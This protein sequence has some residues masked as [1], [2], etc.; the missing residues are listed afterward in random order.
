MTLIFDRRAELDGKAAGHAFLVGVSEYIYLPG[1]N[2]PKR[3]ELYNL[4]RLASPALSAWELCRWLIEHC[5]DLA[6][7]L[8]TI[9]LLASPSARELPKMTPLPAHPALVAPPVP[10]RASWDN[11]LSEALAWRDDAAKATQAGMTFFYYGGHGLQRFGAPLLTL[12]DFAAPTGGSLQRSCELMANFI[13]GMAPAPSRPNIARTQF[14]FIDSCRENLVNAQGLSATPGTVWDPLPSQDDRASPV[15]MASYPGERALSIAGEPSDFCK[16]LLHCLEIGAENSE[17]G[18][19]ARRWPVTSFTLNTALERYFTKL[20]TGQYA[21]ATGVNF[22]NV[23]L[24]WLAAAPPVEF[25]VTIGPDP[26]IDCTS[27]TVNR[28]GTGP[29]GSVAAARAMHPYTFSSRAGIFELV[30]NAGGV[31]PTL[32]EIQ[33]INQQSPVWPVRMGAA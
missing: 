9:R 19:P 8:A 21:P 32:T 14:Y 24:R 17:L 25:Q 28:I 7:P 31:F 22:K 16:A 10:E 33:L 6:V 29:V 13:I 20:G 27:V 30:A 11:F 1:D 18:D 4:K 26:A 15:F 3:E 23:R 2:E 12:D 5:D